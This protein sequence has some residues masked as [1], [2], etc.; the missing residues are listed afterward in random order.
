[1]RRYRAKLPIT[2]KKLYEQRA[3]EA[4][5]RKLAEIRGCKDDTPQHQES[6]VQMMD[7]ICSSAFDVPL[8]MEQDPNTAQDRSISESESSDYDTYC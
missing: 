5:R 4:S 7:N 6:D 8:K 3:L 1:M 2:Y